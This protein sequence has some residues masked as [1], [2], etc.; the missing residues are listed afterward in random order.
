MVAV[1]IQCTSI[2][3]SNS[4]KLDTRYSSMLYCAVLMSRKDRNLKNVY[5]RFQGADFQQKKFRF[6][7]E[8]AYNVRWLP[9][10]VKERLWD[11]VRQSVENVNSPYDLEV[12]YEILAQR[13]NEHK[14]HIKEV[15]P[16]EENKPNPRA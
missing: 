15:F 8:K 14:Q 16:K 5:E 2:L 11:T 9:P 3:K 12:Q 4:S 6:A 1:K 10:E 13:A 7:L